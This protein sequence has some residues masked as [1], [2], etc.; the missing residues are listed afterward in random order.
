[1]ADWKSLATSDNP[2]MAAM[3]RAMLRR[4]GETLD[5]PPPAEPIP[6]ELWTCP[7]LEVIG[8]PC[9]RK[10]RCKGTGEPTTLESCTVCLMET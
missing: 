8:C 2:V 10:W 7:D 4:G 1:M 3:A 5:P 9:R 6:D